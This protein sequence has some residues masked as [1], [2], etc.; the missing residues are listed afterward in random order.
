[1]SSLDLELQEEGIKMKNFYQKPSRTI[2]MLSKSK[3]LLSFCV[4]FMLLIGT[5]WAQ[6]PTPEKFV[7]EVT[8][9]A[10]NQTFAIPLSGRSNGADGGQ[11][12]SSGNEQG[13]SRTRPPGYG[14]QQRTRQ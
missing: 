11:A 2:D 8:T 1:M 6:T 4:G 9:T 13:K 5:A 3:F 7:F 14:L 12:V 10:A